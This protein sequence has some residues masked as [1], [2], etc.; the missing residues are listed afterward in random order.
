M[1]KNKEALA[2]SQRC[3]DT[4]KELLRN[5]NPE[6]QKKIKV[7]DTRLPELLDLHA[8]A[9]ETYEESQKR[10]QTNMKYIKILEEKIGV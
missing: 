10:F 5:M 8:M 3:L 9:K 1:R 7:T 4:A 2:E 6:D